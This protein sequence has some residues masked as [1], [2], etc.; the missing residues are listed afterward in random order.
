MVGQ[1]DRADGVGQKLPDAK[2]CPAGRPVDDLSSG[3]PGAAPMMQGAPDEPV[4]V[5]FSDKQNQG[6]PDRPFQY[7]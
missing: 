4:L 7:L 3:G 2:A 1:G 5:V 6:N